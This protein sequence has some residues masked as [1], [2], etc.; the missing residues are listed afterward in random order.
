MTGVK[1]NKGS[2]QLKNFLVNF[3]FWSGTVWR[4]P[5]P[6]SGQHGDGNGNGACSE[7]CQHSE[8]SFWP[9]HLLTGYSSDG[10]P[11]SGPA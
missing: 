4:W 10:W 2:H 11:V 9:H 1:S 3:R 7:D 6:D 8:C 5:G